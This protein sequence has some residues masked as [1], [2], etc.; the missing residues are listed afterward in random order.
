MAPFR[1]RLARAAAAARGRQIKV[2]DIEAR[3]GTRF[4]A[5]TIAVLRRRFPAT[6]FV[7][8]MGADNLGQMDHWERWEDIFRAVPIAVFARPSYSLR[9]LSQRAAQRF[10]RRRVPVEAARNLAEFAAPAWVFF[11]SRLDSRSATEIRSR[12]D[13]GQGRGG[14]V[15]A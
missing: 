8:L 12:L 15:N 9:A 6:R 7:W 3:L 11:P 4:T 5:D 13:A 10:A 14:T 2:S 1:E